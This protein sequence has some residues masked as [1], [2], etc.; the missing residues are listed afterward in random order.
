MITP[1]IA[2]P[3]PSYPSLPAES[4]YTHTR[5]LPPHKAQGGFPARAPR[6]SDWEILGED[7]DGVVG[8]VDIRELRDAE[9]AVF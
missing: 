4:I 8:W 6:G 5:H 2:R 9:L 1:I 3:L 7:D